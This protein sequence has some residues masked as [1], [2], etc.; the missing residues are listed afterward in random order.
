[1]EAASQAATYAVTEPSHTVHYYNGVTGDAKTVL[2]S[3]TYAPSWYDRNNGYITY[4][5]VDA[6]SITNVGMYTIKATLPNNGNLK[7]SGKADPK[8]VPSGEEAESDYVRYF[9]IRVAKHYI[10]MPTSIEKVYNGEDWLSHRDWYTE[11][12]AKVVTFVVDGIPDSTIINA[13]STPYE[14][15][16]TLSD[17]TNYAWGEPGMTDVQTTL[18]TI[19]A[20]PIRIVVTWKSD[21]ELEGELDNERAVGKDNVGVGFVYTSTEGYN[22]TI[23]PTTQPGHYT[24]T[25][26]IYDADEGDD[27]TVPSANYVVDTSSNNY[28]STFTFEITAQESNSVSDNND[29]SGTSNTDTTDGSGTG[30]TNLGDGSGTNNTNTGDGSSLGNIDTID[31]NGTENNEAIDGSG[32]GNNGTIDENG[33][34]NANI[35][36]GT[37]SNNTDTTN[38]TSANNTDTTDETNVDNTANV[39]EDT[40]T[41][42]ESFPAWQVAAIVIGAAIAV[43]ALVVGTTSLS[44]AKKMNKLHKDK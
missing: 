26:Y 4:T 6:D 34:N 37:G 5:I 23:A 42:K 19:K 38:G 10:S 12:V 17:T 9:T 44:S 35:T 36:D 29:N 30:N 15:T 22:S 28:P 21:T 43:A 11:D 7:W 14:V 33:T 25:A 18:V 13:R 27:I 1:L 32:S 2:D 41:V 24:A 3:I 16:A 39:T 40:A 31:G 8:D 20:K